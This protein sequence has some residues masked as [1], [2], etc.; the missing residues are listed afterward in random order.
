[1]R[2]QQN[3][4][5]GGN[6]PQVNN[7]Q[8]SI[9]ARTIFNKTKRFV[10]YKF[11]IDIFTMIV[12][13]V[14]G[15]VAFLVANAASPIA[16]FS[17]ETTPGSGDY[18]YLDISGG[19]IMPW[20]GAIALWLILGSIVQLVINVFWRFRVRI[21]HVAVVT[22][23]TL[24]NKLPEGGLVKYGME[25]TKSRIGAMGTVG[26]FAFCWLVRGAAVQISS[27]IQGLF[28]RLAGGLGMGG[29]AVGSVVGAGVGKTAKVAT[30]SASEVSLAWT[31]YRTDLRPMRSAV[32]GL[33]LYFRN[34]QTMLGASFGTAMIKMLVLGAFWVFAAI[35]VLIAVTS[36]SWFLIIG[37]LA[38]VMIGQAI[39]NAFLDSYRMVR[40][41]S[42]Y[43][44]VAPVTN[45]DN[46][47][48]NAMRMC[49]KYMMIENRAARDEQQFGTGTG[50]PP[51]P[52]NNGQVGFSTPNAPAP[53]AARPASRNAAPAQPKFDPITGQPIAQPS[54]PRP[55]FDPMT[56]QPIVD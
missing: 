19:S 31:F 28:G 53:N 51:P 55:K 26:F 16:D 22:D 1:M 48:R 5:Q 24:D 47:T 49:P 33:G 18:H 15:A 17:F 7:G 40:M 46:Q 11:S 13:V 3:N 6:G 35:M 39:K 29:S 20:I 45:I 56:G 36:G 30:K 50:T 8:Q 52:I 2:G 25:K 10:W 14:L 41:V 38:F 43:M 23:A 44:K 37:A 34:W 54:A 27:R 9:R 42:D 32:D 21:A 4:M 12:W